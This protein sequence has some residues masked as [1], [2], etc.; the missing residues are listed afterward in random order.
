[1]FPLQLNPHGTHGKFIWERVTA[2]PQPE[3]HAR[4]E[5]RSRNTRREKDLIN[6]QIRLFLNRAAECSQVPLKGQA[7][8]EKKGR[9]EEKIKP[10]KSHEYT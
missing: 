8:R 6:F 3:R 5:K 1:M 7:P 9:R 10:A 4:E 2:V